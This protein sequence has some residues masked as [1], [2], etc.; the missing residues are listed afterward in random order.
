MGLAGAAGGAAN[1]L[2]QILARQLLEAQM[3]QRQEESQQRL[4]MDRDRMGMERER[5]G[6]MLQQATQQQREGQAQGL[7]GAMD[8]QFDPGAANVLDPEVPD[9]MMEALRGTTQAPRVREIQTLTA[10]GVTPELAN[11][12]DQTPQVGVRRLSPTGAQQGQ[13]RV[14]EGVRKI[15]GQLRGAATPEDRQSAAIDGFEQGIDVPAHLLQD[16]QDAPDLSRSSLDVQAA[17]ALR[18]GNMEEYQRLMRAKREVGDAGR[19]PQSFIIQQQTRDDAEGIAQRIV[20]GLDPPVISARVEGPVRAAIARIAPEYDL[21]R[22]RNDFQGIQRHVSSLNNPQQLRLR[23]TAF[24]ALNSLEYL[25]EVVG[26]YEKLGGGKN[27]RTW[28]QFQNWAAEQGLTSPEYTEAFRML[29][30]LV[31]DQESEVAT[32]YRGGNSPTDQTLLRA[33]QNLNTNWSTQSMKRLI[34]LQKRQLNLR[35]QAIEQARPVG[36]GGGTNMYDPGP[37]GGQTPPPRG[38]ES[39]AGGAAAPRRMRFDAQGNPIPE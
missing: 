23:Q 28:N 14:I 12:V 9:E 27:V 25:D 31:T 36:T 24:S 3:R 6:H 11:T 15:A 10:R 4:S 38:G 20:D 2:E 29:N 34:G 37:G 18:A 13:R 16:E 39:P 22:A 8:A 17:A 26:Q 32:V 1:A 19:S 7:V 5:L 33:A 35:I 21:S 30:A